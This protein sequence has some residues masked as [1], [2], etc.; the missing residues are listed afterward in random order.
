M[1][2]SSVVMCNILFV[3]YELK[4]LISV[5]L[6]V[7]LMLFSVCKTTKSSCARCDVSQRQPVAMCHNCALLIINLMANPDKG[8]KMCAHNLTDHSFNPIFAQIHTQKRITFFNHS[9][10]YDIVHTHTFFFNLRLDSCNVNSEINLCMC[11]V[12]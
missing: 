8:R 7:E 5:E 4:I 12:F 10:L 9:K 1:P 3:K 11:D 6:D 2:S